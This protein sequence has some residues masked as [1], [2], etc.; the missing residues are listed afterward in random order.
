MK[1]KYGD[2]LDLRI[3]LTHSEEARKY[4]LKSAA[5]VLIDN[6]LVPLDVATDRGKMA[7]LLAQKIGLK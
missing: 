5:N 7:H 4:K 3:H 2:K 1:E 6:E